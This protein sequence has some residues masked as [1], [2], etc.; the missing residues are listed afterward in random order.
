VNNPGDGIF[1]TTTGS[2]PN[3]TFYVEWRAHRCCGTGT[4]AVNFEV[5]FRESSSTI[6]YIYGSNAEA[7][8]GSSATIGVQSNP[9]GSFTELGANVSGL[10]TP[11]KRFELLIPTAPSPTGGAHILVVYSD[12]G[13]SG[14]GPHAANPTTK[15]P[16][17][18]PAT[19]RNQ[20]AALPGIAAVDDYDAST[21]TPTVA[22]LSGYEAVVP[23]SNF[24]Y[25]D[26]VTLGNNLADYEQ[27]DNG[28]VV[29]YAYDWFGSSQTI[30]GRWLSGGYTPFNAGGGNVNTPATLGT[31]VLGHP[32]MTGVSALN[33]SN[34]Q[35]PITLA[36]GRPS[37]RAGTTA[38]R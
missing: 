29:G 31:F 14:Q 2:A 32:L 20:L 25:S 27:F 7:T 19:F 9:T 3:R 37:S 18:T 38:S 24:G 21:S 26:P 6:R 35:G 5:A 8:P 28:V 10:V 22:L 4:A 11:G 30:Q 13:P 33:D 36:P 1:T 34:R 12:G 23:F 15:Q 17:T 16:F